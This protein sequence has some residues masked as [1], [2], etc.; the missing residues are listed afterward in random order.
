MFLISVSASSD[1]TNRVKW[2]RWTDISLGVVTER[3]RK[4]ALSRQQQQFCLTWF[5]MMFITDGALLWCSWRTE[6][7]LRAQCRVSAFQS[8]VS[9]VQMIIIFPCMR[10]NITRRGSKITAAALKAWGIMWRKCRDLH[11][12]SFE[13]F[14]VGDLDQRKEM[15]TTAAGFKTEG[16]NRISR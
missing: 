9:P 13:L 10:V 4:T 8:R 12:R 7:L 14:L 11:W 3:V 1:S 5:D 16:Y 2:W 6:L 15:R